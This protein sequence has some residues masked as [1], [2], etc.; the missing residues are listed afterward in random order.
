M[1]EGT[2]RD[3]DKS[4][5]V[6]EVG[7]ATLLS[8]VVDAETPGLVIFSGEQLNGQDTSRDAMSVRAKFAKP[9]IDRKM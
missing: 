4:P 8:K 5:C 3:T 6:G 9:V 1:G 7:T 2:C